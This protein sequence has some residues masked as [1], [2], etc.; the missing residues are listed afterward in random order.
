MRPISLVLTLKAEYHKINLATYHPSF[1][2]R[3]DNYGKYFKRGMRILLN[4]ICQR[5]L[6]LLLLAN[7]TQGQM[8]NTTYTVA[9]H[10]SL[11]FLWHI[12]NKY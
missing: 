12:K 1:W 11:G 4:S 6:D 10:R 3:E 5:E 8:Y 9:C 7:D 2:R